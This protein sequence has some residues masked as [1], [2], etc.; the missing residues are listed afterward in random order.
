MQ[1]QFHSVRAILCLPLALLILAGCASPS[2]VPTPIPATPPTPVAHNGDW[3]PLV[4]VFDGV[5]MVLVPPGCFTMGSDTGEPDESPAHL[6]CFDEPFWIDMYEVTN[7]QYGSFG[8]F[9]GPN[10]PREMVGW[11]QAG[12]HCR[13]R[14]VRL[15]TEA[16][17]EYAARGPDSW[18]YPWGDVFDPDKVCHIWNSSRRTCDVGSWPGGVSWVGAYDLSGNVYEWCSTIY[19][20]YDVPW[21]FS[22]D[23]PFIKPAYHRQQI[24]T[25][26]YPYDPADGREDAC[27]SGNDYAHYVLRG[28]SWGDFVLET[29]R[30]SNRYANH[31]GS[32]GSAFG[33][34]CARSY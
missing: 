13:A 24:L 32:Y 12:A 19:Q 11:E 30:A 8:E 2:S 25:F 5:S 21:G 27:C 26:G 9:N 6:Q 22:T 7:N 20:R 29:L 33:F 23:L 4:R 18:V 1:R 34:R 16:E 17:W 14:G 10:Q 28:G 31:P 15:P 3:T